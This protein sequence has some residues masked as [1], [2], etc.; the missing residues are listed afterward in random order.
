MTK[1]AHVLQGLRPLHECPCKD[2]LSLKTVWMGNILSNEMTPP[3]NSDTEEDV[4][5]NDIPE[6]ADSWTDMSSYL[7]EDDPY[8]ES[9]EDS[10][11]DEE[12]ECD[13]ESKWYEHFELDEYFEWDDEADDEADEDS[14][15]RKFY[16]MC[17]EPADLIT[18]ANIYFG[19]S[20]CKGM[21]KVLPRYVMSHWK[22]MS[23]W[24]GKPLKEKYRTIGWK[25]FDIFHWTQEKRHA[26]RKMNE[27]N[28]EDGLAKL[29]AYCKKYGIEYDIE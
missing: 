3:P 18:K 6:E 22:T 27:C 12:S 20:Y 1:Y 25:D 10:E 5:T 8:S 21:T 16:K 26:Q 15:D 11:W 17:E 7:S 28:F 29:R 13:E 14:E 9:D 23:P 24:N 2:S 4:V 19:K